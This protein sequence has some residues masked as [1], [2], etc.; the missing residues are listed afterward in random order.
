MLQDSQA[1][2][3]LAGQQHEQALKQVAAITK[4]TQASLEATSKTASSSI[5]EVRDRFEGQITAL[6][7]RA[8]GNIK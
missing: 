3:D 8:A 4:A 1:A 5:K 6:H 2:I 7:S